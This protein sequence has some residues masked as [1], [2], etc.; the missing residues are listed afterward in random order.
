MES[1]H[2]HS[3]DTFPKYFRF[4]RQCSLLQ[5][6]GGLRPPAPRS[7]AAFSG[8]PNAE[9]E[10]AQPASEQPPSARRDAPS[11]PK[12]CDRGTSRTPSAAASSRM[13]CTEVGG[14][15][16][17]SGDGM[18]VCTQP[19]ERMATMLRSLETAAEGEA[20]GEEEGEEEVVK[21]GVEAVGRVE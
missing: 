15:R 2:A 1:K 3:M 8:S 12:H 13:A 11:S 16:G 18:E 19:W 10:H 5:V 6:A 9:P 17:C 4:L 7:P 14:V 20:E 21:E